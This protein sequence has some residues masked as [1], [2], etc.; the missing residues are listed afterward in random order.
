VESTVPSAEIRIDGEPPTAD[1]QGRFVVQQGVHAVDVTAPGHEPLHKKVR[2]T[3]GQLVKVRADLRSQAAVDRTNTV[4]Y[5][6]VYTGVGLVV[7]GAATAVLSLRASDQARDWWVIETTRPPLIDTSDVHPIKTREDIE[8]KVDESKRYAL[9]SNISYGAAA[10][11]IGVGAYFLVKGR[12]RGAKK[13]KA[14]MTFV[15]VVGDG[16]VGAAAL[17]EVR[18]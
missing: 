4:G 14:T 7:V 6:F 18:W 9:I 2:V 15:P 11:A 1:E 5:T 17:G 13:E 16:G 10:V 8:K 3:K 12:P